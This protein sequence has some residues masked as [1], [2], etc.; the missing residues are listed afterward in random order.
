VEAWDVLPVT[1]TFLLSFTL[2]NPET[3]LTDYADYLEK[4]KE[5]NSYRERRNKLDDMTGCKSTDIFTSLG[6]AEIAFAQLTCDNNTYQVSM[7]KSSNPK[8]A[9]ETLQKLSEQRNLTFIESQEKS[10]GRNTIVYRHPAKGLLG[11]IIDTVLFNGNDQY[12]T[13][14]DNFFYFSDDSNILK[15]IAAFSTKNSLKKRL[16]QTK[17]KAYF[18]NNSNIMLLLRAP[19]QA[20]KTLMGIFNKHIQENFS[21]LS[22]QYENNVHA[23]QLYPEND[24][25][26]VN[27]FT[28]YST[29]PGVTEPAADTIKNAVANAAAGSSTPPGKSSGNKLS[30]VLQVEVINHY[31]KEKEYFVQYSD[32][33]FALRKKAGQQLWRNKFSAPIT[34][35]VLQID[36]LNNKKLQ[37]LFI[38]GRKLY[39]YDR[40]GNT[41][42]PFPITLQSAI[43]LKSGSAVAVQKQPRALKISKD[44]KTTVIYL[45]NGKTE[46]K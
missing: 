16:L 42:K 22:V 4:Y 45:N 19:Q 31:T 44:G 5:L 40:N 8:Y 13:L 37:Y 9:L 23:L 35:S 11:A 1:T 26:F 38:A 12:F 21:Q 33:S 24:K 34:G 32:N 25:F 29:E 20:G 39:L 36:F 27:F 43:T 28:F 10:E 17:A 46:H 18:N 6:P 7:I 41:V 30:E 14:I 15:N 3:F 2:N